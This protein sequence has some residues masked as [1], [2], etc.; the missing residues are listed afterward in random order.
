MIVLVG[1]LGMAATLPA[2]THGLGLIQ[3]SLIA[4]LKLSGG[5]FAWWNFYATLLGAIA[6]LPC[7]WLIDKL[8]SRIVLTAVTAGLGATVLAMTRTTD[9]NMMF[10][11]LVSTPLGRNAWIASLTI[12]EKWF[13]RRISLAMGLFAI[14]MTVGMVALIVLAQDKL[15]K[16]DWRTAW[17]RS[18]TWCWPCRRSA[19]SSAPASRETA[20]GCASSPRCTRPQ[21]R[22]NRRRRARRGAERSPLRRSG[23]SRWRCRSS[24][25]GYAGVSLFQQDIIKERGFDLG[26]YF[27]TLKLG[28]FVGLGTNLVAGSG[29]GMGVPLGKL[30]AVGMLI[31]GGARIWCSRYLEESTHLLP[32]HLRP[33]HR[34][35]HRDVCR[36]LRRLGVAVRSARSGAD[37]GAATVL[38]TVLASAFGPMLV[39]GSREATG[40]FTPDLSDLCGRLFHVRGR[41]VA[42]SRAERGGR[43]PGEEGAGISVTAGTPSR[44]AARRGVGYAMKAM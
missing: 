28:L 4:D 16:G 40:S 33:G 42:D 17:N 2:R 25:A 26:L 18:A 41:G 21:Q 43:L 10:W 31:L 13:L 5:E 6:C 20:A 3:P 32:L 19:S 34:R 24:S 22:P 12:I 35:R 36:L 29:S 30:L 23:S 37:S 38:L 7:G 11:L 27:E 1:S 44:E 9:P 8:G 14:L 39:S 15:G